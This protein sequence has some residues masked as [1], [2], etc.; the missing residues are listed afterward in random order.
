MN[1][2]SAATL[3][4]LGQAAARSMTV[5]DNFSGASNLAGLIESLNKVPTDAITF[6]TMPWQLDPAA[7]AHVLPLQPDAGQMFQYVQRDVSY[8]QPQS[9]ASASAAASVSGSATASTA[10]APSADASAA[11]ALLTTAVLADLAAPTPPAVS[12]ET[13]A[14]DSASECIPVG[15]GNL[16]MAHR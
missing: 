15:S 2:G 4:S 7:P 13:N 1:L 9:T 6:V 12:D 8:A 11:V 10:P 5:S 14:L 3:L 16:A